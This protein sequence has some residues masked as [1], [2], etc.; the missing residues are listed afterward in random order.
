[1]TITLT[2]HGQTV[3]GSVPVTVLGITVMPG[4]MTLQTGATQQL[5]AMV[6]LR[7]DAPAGTSRGVLY[8][9][10]DTTVAT[11]SPTGLVTGRRNG[12]AAI[13]VAMAASPT[14]TRTVPVTVRGG[15]LQATFQSITTGD[16]PV[17]IDP[18]AVRGRIRVTVNVRDAEGYGTLR[19][20]ELWLAG[21]RAVALDG[22]AFVRDGVTPVT[23]EIDT[24][25]RDPQ[26]NARLYPNGAALL[27]FRLEFAPPGATTGQGVIVQLPLTLANP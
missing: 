16:P 7:P 27:E 18:A 8:A 17:S 2:A 6:T 23:M 20:A 21:R 5:E 19:L 25:A 9:S 4:A 14:T 15:V 3:T 13:T 12:T 24:A 11:V 22:I 26:P 10:S 1:V